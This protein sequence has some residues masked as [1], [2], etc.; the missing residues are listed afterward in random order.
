MRTETSSLLPLLLVAL[1]MAPLPAAAQAKE[2]DPLVGTWTGKLSVPSGGS[3][4]LVFHVA[5]KDDGTLTATMDSPAQGA[6]GI[7]LSEVSRAGTKVHLG[8]AFGAFDGTMSGDHA[9]ID[10]TWSQGGASLPLALERGVAAP[11]PPR[12]QEP[13]PPF[14]YRSEDVHIPVP[15]T[16]VVLAGTL[17]LPQG[18][19]PFPAVVLVTGSGPQDR[20]ETVMGH[21]PFLVLSDYL[22]RQG[23]AVLRCDDRGVAQSTGDFATA[24]TRDFAN[25]ALAQVEFLHARPEI[26]HDRIGVVG[27]SEGGLIAPMVAV[28]SKDVAFI[29]LMA[30]PGLPGLEIIQDQGE[31][32]G[33]AAGTPEDVLEVNKRLQGQMAAILAAEPDPQAAVPKLRA[34]I[35]A[36]S[37]SLS[38]ALGEDLRKAMDVTI[39]QVNSPWMRFFLAYDPRPTLEK[40]RVPVLAVDGSKDLQVPPEQDLD[41]IAK[42]LRKGGDRDVTTVLLPGL[43]HLFQKAE[44]GL[45]SEYASIP[46][47]M[48]PTALS[49][50]STWILKRFGNRS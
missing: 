41:A 21:K 14:P 39:R 17:T 9:S 29:V 2:P 32:I 34:A 49:A 10:G 27:H 8:A 12:P 28:R 38:P 13:K 11:A 46:E 18:R 23:I 50:I 31:L 22:T 3:L 19:G 5:A 40:V 20:N 6:T 48:D 24:T 45:P 16:D 25:D 42:A 1:G 7:P 44:T 43:N 37:D 26:A 15:G 33:R 47:T 36:A 4:P 30:G 35:E